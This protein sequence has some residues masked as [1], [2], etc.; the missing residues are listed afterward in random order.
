MRRARPSALMATVALACLLLVSGGAA[1]VQSRARPTGT[2]VDSPVT[3]GAGGI[4]V[5]ATYRHR[6]PPTGSTPAALLIAGS[7]P[8]DR[9][10]NSPE[11]SGSVDTLKTVADWLSQDGVASLRYDKLGSGRTGLGPYLLDPATIGIKPFDEEAV[12]ALTY[13]AGRP[14]VDRRRL[15]VVGHSEGALFALL[16]A[17][18]MAGPAPAVHALGL[19]EPLSVRYLDLISDQITAQIVAASGSG[20]MTAGAAATLEHQLAAAISSLRA[21]G[22]LPADVPQVLSSVF[23]PANALFLSQADRDDP[24]QLAAQLRPPTPVLVSCSN[25]DIQ[26]SCAEVDHLVSGLGESHVQIDFVQLAGVD[27]VLKQDPSRTALAYTE[28]LPFSPQLRAALQTFVRQ[29]L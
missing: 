7:G 22:K 6:L 8:T 12:A 20:Q 23:S 17:T 3:F 10:G 4:T 18:G 16:L 2:W 25:D 14:G 19:L 28:P 21:D 29:H 13:L 27:H 11:L 26:V 9:N 15:A 24:A 1:A 5:Y